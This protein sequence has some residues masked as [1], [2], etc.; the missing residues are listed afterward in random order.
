MSTLLEGLKQFSGKGRVFQSSLNIL[1]GAEINVN[2]QAYKS[3]RLSKPERVP[4][5]RPEAA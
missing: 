5:R 4:Q 1:I 3:L 2:L